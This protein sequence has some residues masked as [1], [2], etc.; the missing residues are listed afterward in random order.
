MAGRKKNDDV[1]ILRVRKGATLKE[2]YAAAHRAFTAAD[3]QRYTE[4]EETFPMEP[5]I[6]ELEAVDKEERAKRRQKRKPK[7]G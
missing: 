1:P 7:N 6:A 4:I 5:L 2:I 3:L